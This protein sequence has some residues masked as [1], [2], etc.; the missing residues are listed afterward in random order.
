MQLCKNV[1]FEAS[2]KSVKRVTLIGREFQRHWAVWLKAPDPE[3]DN[4]TGVVVRSMKK[5]DGT[6][7]KVCRCE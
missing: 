1:C 2:F 4:Q 5:K 7:Q 6:V 3:E